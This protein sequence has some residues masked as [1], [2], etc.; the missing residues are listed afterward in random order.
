MLEIVI[1]RKDV[2]LPDGNCYII[3]KDGVFLKKD[4]GLISGIVKVEKLSFLEAIQAEAKIKIPVLPLD[5]CIQARM[6]FKEVYRRYHSE[7]IVLLYFDE[8]KNEYL[9]SVPLQTVSYAS[10]RYEPSFKE[11]G[12]KLVGSIHSHANFGAFHSPVDHKDESDFDGLHITI[13][14]VNQKSFSI[15]MEVVVNNNRFP[16]EPLN[17]MPELREIE[18]KSPKA[19]T[20]AKESF[21]LTNIPADKDELATGALGSENS[22][23][24]NLHRFDF[25]FPREKKYQFILPAEKVIEDYPFPPEWLEMVK[26]YRPVMAY[27]PISQDFVN[28]K[29]PT[30]ET[31]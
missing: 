19:R 9:L 6:F 15:S 18:R 5:L 28:E 10:L 8:K 14:H 12:F 21:D 4:T 17:W 31:R 3:A 7:S 25:G 1:Y 24:D 23:N 16:Q 27:Q 20:L 2:T 29:R 22:N 11:N 13:G 30:D 26:V